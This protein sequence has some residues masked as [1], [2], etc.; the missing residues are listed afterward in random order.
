[1][2]L[3]NIQT[4][5]TNQ[6]NQIKNNELFYHNG[7]YYMIEATKYEPRESH[8]KR[9]RYILN[10]LKTGKSISELK[11]LSLI[12]SNIKSFQCEYSDSIMNQCKDVDE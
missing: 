4:L 1:M 10:N 6:M 3:K 11:R 12:W 5:Q 2:R 7:S 8:M 9:V